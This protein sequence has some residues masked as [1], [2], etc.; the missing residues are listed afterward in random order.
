MKWRLGR[1]RQDVYLQ[2]GDAPHGAD[3]YLGSFSTEE[4]AAAA[5]HAVNDGPYFRLLAE[6]D[7]VYYGDKR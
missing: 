1:C 7:R 6:R 3:Q 2:T 4:D 5:V